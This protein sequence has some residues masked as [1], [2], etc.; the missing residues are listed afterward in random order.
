[1]KFFD[2]VATRDA[3]DFESL[4]ARLRQA[5]IDGCHVPLRHAHTLHADGEDEGTVLIMPAWE[6]NGYLGIKTV[7]I[8]PGNARHGLPGLHSTYVLYDGRTGQPLAQLDGNEITSR[9]TAAASALAATYLARPDASRL[10]LMGAGRVGSLVPPAYRSQLP[11]SVVEVWDRDRDAVARLVDGLNRLGF[12]ASPVTNL[13]ASIRRAD[14]V[15]CATLAT[16]PIV[17]GAWLAPGSHLD[18]IGSFTP[19]MREADDDC[20]RQA[21]IYVD[22]DE[23]PQKSGDLLGPLARNVIAPDRLNR[24]LTALCRGEAQGRTNDSQRTVFKA[25]GTAL[26]DLAAAVQIVEKTN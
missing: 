25:V 23:A 20:F 7:N 1:M 18:L 8:F 19:R 22:T 15:T 14:V 26:E 4:V 10:V 2:A 21:E 11:I 17:R 5:F 24:T 16:E 12:D 3:L 13:E 6:D 9:R